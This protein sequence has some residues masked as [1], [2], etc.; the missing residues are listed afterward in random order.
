M[1]DPLIIQRLI[2]PPAR[3]APKTPLSPSQYRD[4]LTKNE[5]TLATK[6][7]RQEAI[8]DRITTL[9]R[10][11]NHLALEID[12]LQKRITYLRKHLTG[13]RSV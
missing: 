13:M 5:L 1:L 10:K 9:T 8:R 12:R 6:L 4:W 3:K 11:Q 2:P 7:K